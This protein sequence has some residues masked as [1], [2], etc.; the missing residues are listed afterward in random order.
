MTQ[1]D[2]PSPTVLN[3]AV[4]TLMRQWISMVAGGAGVQDGWGREVIHCTVFFCADNSLVTS[5]NPIWMQ[6][7]FITLTGLFYRMGIQKNVGKIVGM[8][9]RP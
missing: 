8:L 3:M 7:K 1:G 4:E 9:C 2:P 6:G 5:N